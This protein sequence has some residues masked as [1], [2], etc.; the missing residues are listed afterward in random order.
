[1]RVKNIPAVAPVEFQGETQEKSSLKF[2]EVI[3]GETS[4]KTENERTLVASLVEIPK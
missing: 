2:L 3:T 1:M 4:D